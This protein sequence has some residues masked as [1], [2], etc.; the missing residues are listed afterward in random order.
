MWFGLGFYSLL[1]LTQTCKMTSM[2]C[3]IP[4]LQAVKSG[5]FKSP[6]IG[7]FRHT[8]AAQFAEKANFGSRRSLKMSAFIFP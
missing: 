1:L 3:P 7:E 2:N 6:P 5:L 4:L 8:S